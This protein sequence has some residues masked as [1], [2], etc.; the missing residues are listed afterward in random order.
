MTEHAHTIQK[1]GTVN[2]IGLRRANGIWVPLA[3][4][5]ECGEPLSSTQILAIVERE[6]VQVSE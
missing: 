2:K 1:E 4:C 6:R 5:H 3:S